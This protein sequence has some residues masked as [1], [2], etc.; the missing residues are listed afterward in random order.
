MPLRPDRRRLVAALC[1]L[2]PASLP[3]ADSAP[4]A[5]PRGVA[6]LFVDDL[7][8]ADSTGLRRTLRQPRK[9]GGG[10]NPLIAPA[11]GQ[12]LQAYGSIVRDARLG[13]FVMFVREHMGG[14]GFFLATSSDGLNWDQ[15]RREE[16]IPVTFDEGLEPDPG[17]GA[18]RGLDMFSCVYDASD[19]AF[20]YKGWLFYANYG[21]GRE[22]TYFV[23]SRDG[24]SWERG[25]Q[26]FNSFS[27]RGDTS[28]RRIEQDGKTVNGPGDVTL[29]AEDPVA[30]RYLGIVKFYREV[31]RDRDANGFRSRAYLFVDRLDAPVDTARINRIAL[32]PAGEA[33]GGDRPADEFYAS[34]AWRQGSHWIGGLKVYHAV[35]DYPYSAAGCAFLKLAVSRDGLE[36]RKVP[37]ANEAGVPEVFLANGPEG[38]NGGRNDGGYVC[39][40]SQGPLRIGDELV[41]YYSATS[42]GKR[43]PAGK[44]ITGGGIFRARLRV[45][46][47]VSVD[48]GSLT[49]PPLACEG[50]DLAV[51]AAGPVD[52]AILAADGRVMASAQVRGDAIAHAV[53]FDGRSLRAAA[54][55]GPWRLRFGVGAGGSL[56][57]FSVR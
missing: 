57:S 9:E 50:S 3:A 22:G 55:P 49:T 25:V 41:Y 51:N 2:L 16:L 14:G 30:G 19:A 40:F 39:E 53:R 31:G 35:D 37:F 5:V 47:F 38:G 23:R 32:L 46:G 54:G 13:K 43:A 1:L 56:Y 33:R 44:R 29:F 7:L 12:D 17:H 24:R 20:P 6:Q 48:A 18:R 21:P 8:V 15:R 42:F 10:E 11:P 27:G 4:L 26:V 36:W 34:T 28:F 45:D 52:V